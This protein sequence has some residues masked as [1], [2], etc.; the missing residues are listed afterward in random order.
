LTTAPADK[1]PVDP[2]RRRFQWILTAAFIAANVVWWLVPSNLAYAI[3]QHRP[4]LLGRYGLAR[5]SWMLLAIPGTLL[6]L[7]VTWA[8]DKRTERLRFGKVVVAAVSTILAVLALDAVLRL[9]QPSYRFRRGWHHRQP[10]QVIRTTE[11]DVPSE[12]FSFVTTPPG[13]PDIHATLTTDARGFRNTSSRN[14]YDLLTIGDSFTDGSHVSDEHV[15]PVLLV[16]KIGRT[17]CN[18]GMGGSRPANY[19]AILTEYGLS[20]SP[21]TV[22]LVLYEGNDF[23]G[24]SGVWNRR[25][26]FSPKRYY[27]GSPLRRMLRETMIQSLAWHN[28]ASK[29][30]L[31]AI[32]WMPFRVPHGQGGKHYTFDVKL[33]ES[34]WMP[35]ERFEASA[36]CRHA[37]DVIGRM[38]EACDARGIRLVVMFAPDRPHV[39]LKLLAPHADAA[40][41][42]AFLALR[43]RDLPPAE[44]FLPEL[45]RRLEGMEN[46]VRE[47]CRQR[48]IPFYSPTERLREASRAGTQT[49]FTYDQHWT[50]AGHAVVAEGLAEFLEPLLAAA[51]SDPPGGG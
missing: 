48:S 2:K 4:V 50:P 16:G 1:K 28:T 23:R 35:A 49:Y 5:F 46:V 7:Y 26:G 12:V 17:V 33:L 42:R 8:A 9:R 29:D 15:W 11:R 20:L 6:A 39:L 27:K 14:H 13:Y 37:F 18:L 19:L 45:L 40:Q 32:S 34:H 25:T 21:K 31:Y 10:N 41:V 38:K 24:V 51:A 47:H 30:E 36:G 43:V 22:V 3:A 44:P